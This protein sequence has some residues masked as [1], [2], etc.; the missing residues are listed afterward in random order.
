MDKKRLNIAVCINS[1]QKGFFFSIAKLLSQKHEVWIIARDKFVHQVGLKLVPE[2]S[3][4]I[5]IKDQYR[6][7]VVDPV[8]GAVEFEKKYGEYFSMLISLDRGLGQGYLFNAQKHPHIIKSTWSHKKKIEAILKEYLFYEDVFKK[9][10]IDVAVGH[11][12]PVVFDIILRKHNKRYFSLGVA[13]ISDRYMW[14]EN[15]FEEK[16]KYVD[17]IRKHLISDQTDRNHIE[18]RQYK[19]FE[20]TKKQLS[21]EYSYSYA[22]YLAFY[23]LLQELYARIRR[24]HKRDGYVFSGWIPYFFRRIHHYKHLLTNG[25]KIN[26]L[27][28]YK[29]V[30]FALH[31]EP[32]MTLMSISPGFHNSM[33]II[34]WVS[35][36]LPGDTL[37]VVKENPWGFGVR[38]KQYYK[39]LAK[40]PNLV[41]AYPDISSIDWIKKAKLVVSISGTVGFEAVYFNK[42]VLSFGAHQ[43]INYLPTVKYANNFF[44]TK[45]SVDQ[46]LKLSTDDGVFEKSKYALNKAQTEMSFSLPGYEKI[47]KSSDLHLDLAEKAV[48]ILSRDYPETVGSMPAKS[49]HN[50]R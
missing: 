8:H 33:E 25:C 47:Y 13:R 36:S 20:E 9:Y 14:F 5:I 10:Q 48:R 26:D 44:D 28:G 49:V 19:H 16:E 18:Y 27:S 34:S 11:D 32:E 38:S 37:L 30:F 29:L 50:E 40:I 31:Q 1:E 2:L 4:N 17:S 6:A 7:D 45:D 43:I 24:I 35:K 22:V 21:K 41:W 42:P 15:H 12:R 23:K 3:N 39:K 46:L